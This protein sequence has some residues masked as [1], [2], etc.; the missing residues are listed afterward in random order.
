MSPAVYSLER[1]G[2]YPASHNCVE[3]MMSDIAEWVEASDGS[4]IPRE[5]V[6]SR[7]DQLGWNRDRSE[8]TPIRPKLT[9]EGEA[10]IAK[11]ARDEGLVPSK[12]QLTMRQYGVSYEEARDYLV[13]Q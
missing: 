11:R 9:A 2:S 10:A 12:V 4:R 6:I 13:A 7:M 5:T 3:E 1:S 8:R